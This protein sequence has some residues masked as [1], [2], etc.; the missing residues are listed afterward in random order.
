[1]DH[2]MRSRGFAVLSRE[3]DQRTLP[4]GRCVQLAPLTTPVFTLHHA[5]EPNSITRHTWDHSHVARLDSVILR[6]DPLARDGS[7][8]GVRCVR[9]T[10]QG[11]D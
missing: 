9:Q 11:S 10:L 8:Y 7:G 4:L 3:F 6:S 5:S 2:A 1:M